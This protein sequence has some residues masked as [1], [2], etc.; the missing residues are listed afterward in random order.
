M[1]KR[2]SDEPTDKASERLRQFEEAR[3]PVPD[4]K[5]IKTNKGKPKQVTKEDKDAAKKSKHKPINKNK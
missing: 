5:S 3:A 2:S 1:V 4:E